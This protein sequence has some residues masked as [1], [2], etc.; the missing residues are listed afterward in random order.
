MFPGY[1]SGAPVLDNVYD[2]RAGLTMPDQRVKSY[3]LMMNVTAELSD[4]FTR[5]DM[6]FGQIRSDL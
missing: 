2:T 6:S 3:G 4:N 1:L 5:I